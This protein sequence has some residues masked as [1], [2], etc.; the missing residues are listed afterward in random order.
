MREQKQ[1]SI[2]TVVKTLNPRLITQP[3]IDDRPDWGRGAGGGG[4]ERGGF[5]RG[6][7]RQHEAWLSIDFCV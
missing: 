6:G 3:D 4:L 1:Q 5:G 2:C 7:S